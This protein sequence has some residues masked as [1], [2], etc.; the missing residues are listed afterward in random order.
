MGIL[1]QKLFEKEKEAKQAAISDLSIAVED[2]H[3]FVV[4]V[5]AVIPGSTIPTF[6]NDVKGWI[7][8]SD[9]GTLYLHLNQSI[10]EQSICV[11]VDENKVSNN[12]KAEIEVNPEADDYNQIKKSLEDNGWELRTHRGRRTHIPHITQAV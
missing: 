12:W 5:I 11:H 8:S 7:N 9:R 3:D 4:Q 6:P 10:T 2:Y 1:F